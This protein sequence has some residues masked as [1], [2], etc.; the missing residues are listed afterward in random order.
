LF[1]ARAQTSAASNA[2]MTMLRRLGLIPLILAMFCAAAAAADA[3]AREVQTV[4]RLLDYIAV[5]YPEAVRD[6]AV[7]SESEFKEMVE[8]SAS[9]RERIEA[10]PASAASPALK[11]KAVGLEKAIADKT[12]APEVARHARDLASELI[13]AYPVPIA[14]ATVPDLARGAR[15]YAEHC[16]SCHGVTGKGDG[17]AAVDAKLDPPPVAFT[18]RE[19]ARE[20]SIFALY[21]V[22]D[23]GLDG[24]SMASFAD[25]LSADERWAVAAYAASLAYPTGRAEGEK[26]WKGEPRL[27]E[28]MNLER[29]MT[30]RPA[31]L[32]AL[33]GEEAGQALV[34]FLR[35]DPG[36]VTAVQTDGRLTLARTRLAS[37]LEA[38]RRGDRKAAT[39]LA[40]S[41]YLDGFEPIEPLLSS[42]DNRLMVRI[43]EAMMA[44]RA[45]IGAGAPV[46]A[47]EK[48]IGDLEPLFTEA[49]AVL[50]AGP[51]STLSAFLA[52]FAI[53]VRE[54]LEALLI[55][56]A[57]V[58][59]LKKADQP[60]M[61]RWVHW[62]WVLALAAGA[63][64]WAVATWAI[65][66]SGASRELTE[67]IGSLLAAI[68]LV[69]VGIW[70]HGKSHADAWQS[71]IRARMQGIV[72]KRSG[73]LLLGLSF[74]VVY[75]EVFE[76]ILFYAALWQDE[77]RAAVLGGAG[78]AVVALA[79]LAGIM[80]RI[81]ARLPIGK[82]FS[83]SAILL[84]ILAVV[85][86]G[87][88]VAALQEAGLLDAQRI[89]AVPRI[90]LLGLYPSLQGVV[91]QALVLAL[92]VGGFLY[93]GRRGRAAA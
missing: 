20:R 23:Q 25:V 82:F 35:H 57:M 30:L 48:G 68:I 1:I 11:A 80:T 15:I 36:A 60:G 88:A 56:V 3:P 53:L 13:A 16:A 44:V 4:W 52:A 71:Y 73:L 74:V 27:R 38:Y 7:V 17:Q 47:I 21:Q 86:M 75:R 92:V 67:G 28:G 5:D 62:G 59:F 90:E 58:A 8:F 51:T 65:G 45:Q 66:I 24:T 83:Y 61:T 37:A 70:M 81:S 78:L 69:W 40:L 29:L 26:L 9:A 19:R 34:A 18:D 93:N 77:N 79:I 85:L 2:A 89:P 42:K 55:V 84:A 6:G 22:I 91:A 33:H 12:P 14:P 10:L 43:E 49:E 32:E 31:E 50:T 64:T 87:K 63:A 72:S 76:T 46:A 54:G 41:A 39:D